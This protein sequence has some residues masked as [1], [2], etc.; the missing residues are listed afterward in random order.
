MYSYLFITMNICG[1]K[2]TSMVLMSINTVLLCP[3]N[4]FDMDVVIETT[5]ILDRS[6]PCDTF[7]TGD[8]SLKS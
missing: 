3:N 4:C 7:H 2:V 5:I 8:L 6:Q 1:L